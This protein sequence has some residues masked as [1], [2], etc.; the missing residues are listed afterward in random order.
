MSGGQEEIKASS[1]KAK[2]ALGLSTV[3]KS[4]YIIVD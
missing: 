3:N 2:Q 4:S 1:N